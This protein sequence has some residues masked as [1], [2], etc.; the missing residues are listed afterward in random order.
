MKLSKKKKKLPNFFFLI[1]V[2]GLG[3]SCLWTNERPADHDRESKAVPSLFKISYPK[4]SAHT[5][6]IPR[7]V[8]VQLLDIF[9][10]S[11]MCKICV[12]LKKKNVNVM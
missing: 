12:D 3:N 5:F 7:R 4:P 10:Q 1:D 8:P 11:I 2:S 6:L 9:L